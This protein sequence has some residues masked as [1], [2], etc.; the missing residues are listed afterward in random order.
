M[1]TLQV[2]WWLGLV[3]VIPFCIAT[4]LVGGWFVAVGYI[5]IGTMIDV[6]PGDRDRNL[7]PRP[8]TRATRQSKKRIPRDSRESTS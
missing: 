2:L 8:Q 3:I 6:F 5:W 7:Y 1:R 4:F